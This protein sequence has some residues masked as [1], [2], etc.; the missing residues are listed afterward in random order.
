MDTVVDYWRVVDDVEGTIELLLFQL[1]TNH[2]YNIVTYYYDN[3]L[4][5]LHVR[6]EWKEDVVGIR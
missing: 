3:I 5:T 4:S 6:V 1:Q 2:G